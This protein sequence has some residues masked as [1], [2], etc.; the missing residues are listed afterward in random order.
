L[1]IAFSIDAIAPLSKGDT[2]SRRGSGTRSSRAA[3]GRVG[4]VVLDHQ[5]LDNGRGRSAGANRGELDLACSITFAMR[6]RVSSI[7]SSTSS[8]SITSPA[9]RRPDRRAPTK[10]PSAIRSK[11]RIGRRLSLQNVIAHIH[12]RRSREMT[13]SKDSS[14]NL[15]ALGLT[16]DLG[17]DAVDPAVSALQ[18]DVGFDLGRALGGGVSVVK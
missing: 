13:S 18:D 7:T 8:F 9:Y 6:S 15:V 4:A 1:E 2:T 10:F 3:S 5:V 12:D 14:S 16:A 11:T 17:I